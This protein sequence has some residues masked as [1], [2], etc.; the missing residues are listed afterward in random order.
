GLEVSPLD[1]GRLGTVETSAAGPEGRTCG[2]EDP[3]V[4]VLRA[5]E[6]DIA[7]YLRQ[8]AIEMRK[9]PSKTRTVRVA[10]LVLH[11]GDEGFLTMADVRNQIAALNLWYARYRIKF[12]LAAAFEV[13]VHATPALF[14]YAPGSDAELAAKSLL[15]RQGY[16][17]RH[18]LRIYSF[19]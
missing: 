15:D 17:P 14:H 5:V 7:P 12:V 8:A 6:R 16:D 10:F 19:G 2:T 13:D 3:P 1:P 9:K 11:D 18:Y 4:P